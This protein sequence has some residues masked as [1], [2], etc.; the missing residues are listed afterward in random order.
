MIDADVVEGR[1]LE[2]ALSRV[3]ENSR[4]SYAHLHYARP[5]CYAGRVDRA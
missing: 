3:L 1:D 5:G 2:Q 4:V